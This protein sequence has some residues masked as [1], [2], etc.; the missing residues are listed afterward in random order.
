MRRKKMIILI[1]LI[2]FCTVQQ[3]FSLNITSMTNEASY[4][5]DYF[6]PL[7]E[8]FATGANS[9][10]AAASDTGK[11]LSFGVQINMTVNPSDAI[12]NEPGNSS[13]YQLPMLY[14]NFK[15][16]RFFIFIRGL[17]ISQDDVTFKYYGGGLGMV[18]IQGTTFFPEIKIL[19]AYQKCEADGAF[20]ELSALT[21]AAIV[22][23]KLPIP[24]LNLNVFAVGGYE[25]NSLKTSWDSTAFPVPINPENL[26]FGLDQ[27]RLSVGTRFEFLGLVALSY[28]FTLKP[29]VN[30]N[31]TASVKL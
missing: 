3:G 28:E 8:M 7:L 31:I 22:D 29:S 16:G 14:A 6:T 21:A 25:R 27:Y 1:A 20:F 15:L 4:N 24:I 12:L 10:L 9:G 23:Y 18:L 19:G 5:K 11:L 30:H 2:S 17:L 13:N 26:D